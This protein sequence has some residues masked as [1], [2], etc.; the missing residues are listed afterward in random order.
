MQYIVFDHM[1][2]CSEQAIKAMLPFVSQQRKE[3]ALKYHHIF[4]QFACLKSF[5]LLAEL[6]HWT[7]S[8][9]SQ[10]SF[11]YNKYG[12][13]MLAEEWINNCEMPYF[14]ISHCKHAIAVVVSESPVGMD[15]ESIR[16][17]DDSLIEYTMSIQE[18]AFIQKS[19][20]PD[21]T[22]TEL[23]TRKESLLKFK[24]TGITENLKN[25]LDDVPK[26]VKQQ[27]EKYQNYILTI[28]TIH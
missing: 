6:M 2:E 22:F 24:G 7:P 21:A 9:V 23:W 18:Q 12:K 26:N 8:I 1:E 4:G 25:V 10:M 27:V 15:V 5:M 14:S 16:K 11:S 19:E 17:I 13:P 28:T 20:N 3:Q